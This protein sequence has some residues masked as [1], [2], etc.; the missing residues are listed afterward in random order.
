MSEQAQAQQ[1]VILVVDDDALLCRALE[2]VLQIK[3][4]RV[5]AATD[6]TLAIEMSRS[7]VG[8]ID[9]VLVDLMMPIQHGF[10]LV[11]I[12]VCE[13]PETKIVLT[14]GAVRE[15]MLLERDRERVHGFLTKPF[16][17]SHLLQLI[18]D[19]LHVV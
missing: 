13:R 8:P 9:L 4:Y 2:R 11:D 1:Q 14:S 6:G 17:S 3:G 19:L 16:T 7:C 15:H 5:L 12:L 18:K 10:S